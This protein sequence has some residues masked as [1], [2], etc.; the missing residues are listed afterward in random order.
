MKHQ[1]SSY[2]GNL[3]ERTLYLSVSDT[4]RMHVHTNFIQSRSIAISKRSKII[5]D[6]AV[7]TEV[8]ID[9]QKGAAITNL[10][11]LLDKLFESGT[12]VSV[13]WH[14]GK[15][16]KTKERYSKRTSFSFSSTALAFGRFKG[17]TSQQHWTRSPKAWFSV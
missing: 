4:T 7:Y 1:Q 10:Q 6:E 13:P 12:S 2:K 14:Q 8:L 16:K 5:T 17:S 11:I 3:G 9:A 15:Q